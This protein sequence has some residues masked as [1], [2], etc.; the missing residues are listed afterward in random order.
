M[1]GSDKEQ[2]T[3]YEENKN[4]TEQKERKQ[5]TKLIKSFGWALQVTIK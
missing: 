2:F 4:R 5:S 1:G 3:F